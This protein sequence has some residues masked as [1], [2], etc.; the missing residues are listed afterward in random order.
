MTVTVRAREVETGAA[1]EFS[2]LAVSPNRRAQSSVTNLASETK[3]K[4]SQ[5]S[6][7]S[8]WVPTCMACT[9][10]PALG[11][12]RHSFSEILGRQETLS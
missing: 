3:M 8:T 6:P 10:I 9:V 7:A 4:N 1:L 5:G 2:G 12:Q 11:R